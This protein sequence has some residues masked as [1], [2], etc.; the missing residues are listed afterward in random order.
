M[1]VGQS[2]QSLVLAYLA[3]KFE[4]DRMYTER[5]VNQVLNQ[6]R[7]YGDWATVRRAL[8]DHGFLIRD[9][10]GTNYQVPK[11]ASEQ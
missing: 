1:R 7:T 11:P 5:E 4:R 9:R 3:G 8:V 2:N 10:N 6:W